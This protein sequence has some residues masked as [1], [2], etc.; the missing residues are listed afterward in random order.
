MDSPRGRILSIEFDGTP[1]SAVVEVPR[2]LGCA[3]CAAG[4]G[5]GAGL[6]GADSQP[7]RIA[8]L[9][10]TGLELNEGDEVSIE[11]APQN[12]LRA[13]LIVY[14]LPLGGAVIGAGIAYLAGA[15]DLGA[16][17]AALVGLAVGLAAGRRY[18]GRAACLK[19]FTPVITGRVAGAGG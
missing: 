4:K 2:S 14:G 7:R 6:T 8:A 16:A 17:F 3:R 19:H 1:P 13:A 12:V 18:L 11:L 15:G 10:A 9:L 5:C